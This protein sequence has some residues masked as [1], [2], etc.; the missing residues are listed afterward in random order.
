M[1]AVIAIAVCMVVLVGLSSVFNLMLKSAL[2]GT[3][4]I[5]AAYLEEEGL[6]AMR[7]LRD[8]SWD[9]NIASRPADSGFYLVFDSGVWQITDANNPI[10]NIFERKITLA[11]VYRDGAQN[12]VSTAGTLDPNT[13]KVTVSVSW[14]DRGVTIV[15]S[16]STYLTNV[17]KN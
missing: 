11:D 1:E 16:L 3:A 17:F 10:D 2:A 12:I 6:E 8:N 14:S 15:R 13:K 4:K 7:L 5:Q 9:A